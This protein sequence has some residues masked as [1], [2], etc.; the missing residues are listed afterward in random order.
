MYL[1]P[2][3]VC[4]YHSPLGASEL[5]KGIRSESRDQC[6]FCVIFY[7]ECTTYPLPPLHLSFVSRKGNNNNLVLTFLKHYMSGAKA[8]LLK[9]NMLRKK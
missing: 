8:K 9:H 3:V 1:M 6:I 2:Y 7:L 5:L 4:F